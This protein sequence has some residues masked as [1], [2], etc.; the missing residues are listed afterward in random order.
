MEK[1]EGH[2]SYYNNLVD[3]TVRK[4][5]WSVNKALAGSEG[6]RAE[7]SAQPSVR[8]SRSRRYESAPTS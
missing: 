3:R 5:E 2:M 1:Q 8:R 7:V 6:Q 4:G